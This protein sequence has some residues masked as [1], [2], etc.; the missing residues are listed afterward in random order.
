MTFSPSKTFILNELLTIV[1]LKIVHTVLAFFFLK[2]IQQGF[3]V[4]GSLFCN[5]FPN[6]SQ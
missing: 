3:K 4:L 1:Y 2:Q 5:I 6:A